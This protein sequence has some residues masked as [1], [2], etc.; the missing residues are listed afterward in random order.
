ME[1]H[2]V[3][4]VDRSTADVHAMNKIHRYVERMYMLV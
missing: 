1:S 4:M 2:S 3:F